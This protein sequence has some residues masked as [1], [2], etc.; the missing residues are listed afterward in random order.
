M[1]AAR[2]YWLGQN[3]AVIGDAKLS[4]IYA[5]ALKTQGGFVSVAN[6][7]EMTIAGLAAARNL[8]G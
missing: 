8:L 6:C 3:I 4:Q 2:P 1:A 5:K 7:Q